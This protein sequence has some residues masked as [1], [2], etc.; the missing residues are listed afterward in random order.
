[1]KV[2]TIQESIDELNVDIAGLK[3]KKD[4]WAKLLGIEGA[5]V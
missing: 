1:L 5:A 3:R 4:E 2:E